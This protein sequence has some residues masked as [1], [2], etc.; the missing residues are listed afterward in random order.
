MLQCVVVCCMSPESR[1]TRVLP[2]TSK[3][4]AVTAHVCGDD[5]PT[6]MSH[7]HKSCHTHMSG[8]THESCR[9]HNESGHMGVT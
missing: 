1:H 2:H 6:L 9:T 3:V 8:D 5:D 7:T 4:T